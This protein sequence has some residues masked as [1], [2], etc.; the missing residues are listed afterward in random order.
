[1]TRIGIGSRRFVLV[2]VV[3]AGMSLTSAAAPTAH[4]A[5]S[6]GARCWVGRV[7]KHRDAKRSYLEG[8][9]A[10]FHIENVGPASQH[11]TGVWRIRRASG[12]RFELSADLGSTASEREVAKV[13][14]NPRSDRP[15]IALM[16]CE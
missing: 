9:Y 8:W 5:A 2:V 6:D 11:V 16:S 1:V 13:S 15:R 7:W 3:A 4:A 14:S 10:A 12:W